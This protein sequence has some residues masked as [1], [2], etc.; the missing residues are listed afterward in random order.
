MKIND[1]IILLSAIVVIVAGLVYIVIP[2]VIQFI[3][4]RKNKKLEKD[5]KNIK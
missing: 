1:I 3:Y 2:R 5:N 4:H